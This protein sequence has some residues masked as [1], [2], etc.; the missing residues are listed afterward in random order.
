MSKEKAKEFLKHLKDNPE[1][2][3]KMK[4]FTKEHLKEAAKELK[5]SGEIA[6]GSDLDT[7]AI[8]PNLVC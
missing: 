8:D 3:E 5:D 1:L 7:F 2:I 4:G 6:E